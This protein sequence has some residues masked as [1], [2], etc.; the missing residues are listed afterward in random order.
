ME[1]EQ[2]SWEF[3]AHLFN[4]AQFP[5]CHNRTNMETEQSSWEFIAHLLAATKG[6]RPFIFELL[7]IH[8]ALYPVE[9]IDRGV[10]Y[11]LHRHYSS[12]SVGHAGFG[13]CL[14]IYIHE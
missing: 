2:S 14:D 9:S 3:I 12:C 11:A 6:D 1:A 10:P 7:H 13:P 8:D 4:T 5:A